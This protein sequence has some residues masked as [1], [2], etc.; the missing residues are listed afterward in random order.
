MCGGGDGSRRS[1][2]LWLEDDS[3]RLGEGEGMVEERRSMYLLHFKVVDRW[4]V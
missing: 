4:N 3:G 2:G 1:C